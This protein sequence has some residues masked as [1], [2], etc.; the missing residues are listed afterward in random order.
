MLLAILFRIIPTAFEISFVC[1]I[2]VSLY[3]V[4]LIGGA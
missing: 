3:L 4:L 2:L 1:G